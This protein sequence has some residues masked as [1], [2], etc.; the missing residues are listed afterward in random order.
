MRTFTLN[1]L[2]IMGSKNEH[3]NI[4]A[5]HHLECDD[6]CIAD[7]LTNVATTSMAAMCIREV[8]DQ[9]VLHFTILYKF[10]F[11]L[12]RHTSRVIHRSKWNFL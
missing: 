12:R 8:D 7:P 2:L 5:I 10:C 4:T 6:R 9:S 3:N 11:A 1:R